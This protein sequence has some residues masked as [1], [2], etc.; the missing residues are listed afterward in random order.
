[1]AA[2]LVTLGI[3]CHNAV[4]WIAE[5]VGS[6]LEQTH[7]PLQ[8]VVVD[9]GSSDGS[10]ERLAPFGDKIEL[11]PQRHGG[12]NRA[13]NEILRR[14]RGEWIQ[15]LDADDYLHPGKIA[16]Q[17]ENSSPDAQVLYS[18]VTE[19]NERTGSRAIMRIDPHF[20]LFERFIT[21]QL[22]QTGGALWRRDALERLG[23]WNESMPCCQEHELYLRALMAG[24]KFE[25]RP[26][27]EAVY[28]VWSEETVCR[29]DP[30]LVIATKT[31]LL[32]QFQAWLRAEGRW[33][34][35]YQDLA[36][37]A[38]FAM[39][40]TRARDDLSA[41]ADY[42]RIRQAKG[43]IRLGGPAA[44]LHYRLVHD[45][46]GFVAAERVARFLR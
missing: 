21:W 28:R 44:P 15:Y 8:I 1:M 43:M 12:G 2:P 11:V 23:G 41:A 13:R 7:A 18:E 42:Y 16:D 5:A 22:P 31:A 9:D 10:L 26:G 36:G 14:A 17:L 46:L 20:D 34:R 27:A 24:M 32:D 35:R 33:R 4:Q 30:A 37:W 45:L 29:R 19:E 25:F 3:P 6:A 39:A 40:R 38:C